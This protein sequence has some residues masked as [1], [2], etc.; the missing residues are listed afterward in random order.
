MVA[1]H[2]LSVVELITGEVRRVRVG[3][4][5]PGQE[6]LDGG[7]SHS[8]ALELAGEVRK[9]DVEVQK[10]LSQHLKLE[11]VVRTSSFDVDLIRILDDVPNS[12]LRG[13]LRG[14][15]ELAEDVADLR[16]SRQ[17]FLLDVEL[18]DVRVV[19]LAN[20]AADH[21]VFTHPVDWQ[22]AL[23]LVDHLLFVYAVYGGC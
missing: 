6:V 15:V 5:L 3:L 20:L 1:L 10:S 21:R 23:N 19:A 4:L 9:I 17:E 18:V 8:I 22:L 2:V 12:V 11:D 16:V 13:I 7:V 14:Y